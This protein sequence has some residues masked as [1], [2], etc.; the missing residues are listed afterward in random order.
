MTTGAKDKL[1]AGTG[2]DIHND[3]L[4]CPLPLCRYDSSPVRAKQVRRSIQIKQMLKQRYWSVE[5]L[6]ERL[7]V[8]TRTVQRAL[9]EHNG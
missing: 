2:C 4:T 7:G 9:K 6:A 1:A 5:D 8:S 3:C